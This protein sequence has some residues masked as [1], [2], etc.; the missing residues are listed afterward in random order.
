MPSP[1]SSLI[2]AI[3]WKPTQ[4]LH[5]GTII[6]IHILM[7]PVKLGYSPNIFFYTKF[8]GLTLSGIRVTPSLNIHTVPF[9]I[10]ES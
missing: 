5:A 3:T 4:R 10:I 7:T 6:M 2:F 9:R 1:T 8:Q